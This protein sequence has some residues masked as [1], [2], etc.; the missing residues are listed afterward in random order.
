[1]HVHQLD[2]SHAAEKRDISPVFSDLF[3][4]NMLLS[5]CQRKIREEVKGKIIVPQIPIDKTIPSE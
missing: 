1:M 4:T 3:I 2:L 5:S